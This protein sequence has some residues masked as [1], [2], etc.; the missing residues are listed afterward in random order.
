MSIIKCLVFDFDGVLVDSNALKRS[1]YFNIFATL[2]QIEEI[3]EGCL[4]ENREGDR[5]QIIGQ[6][7]QKL[8]AASF[9]NMKRRENEL[10][11]HYAE[12]YNT[13]CEAHTVSCQEVP[14]VSA[15]LPH[16]AQ[17]YALY[18]NSATP[19]EPLRRVIQQR[20]WNSYFRGVL[21]RPCSKVENLRWIMKRE[22]IDGR[23]IIF[24]G[25]GQ[26]DLL[27]ARDCSCFFIGMRQESNDFDPQGLILV[28]DWYQLDE[29]LRERWG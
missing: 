14:G 23:S 16:L 8:E 22:G 12:E 15:C 29:V 10:L 17:R 28:D 25:D 1:A 18:I 21:G 7:L 20:Q 27:A 11:T 5:F 13:I 24:V 26:Q 2:G 9:L 6:L 3:V 19:E 4:R